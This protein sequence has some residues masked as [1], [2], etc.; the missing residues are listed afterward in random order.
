M[1]ILDLV[2]DI[3]DNENLGNENFGVLDMASDL[4]DAVRGLHTARRCGSS[5]YVYRPQDTYVMGWNTC[6]AL[7]IEPRVSRTR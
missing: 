3:K 6:P 1:L 7:C 5:M 4:K 2:Q